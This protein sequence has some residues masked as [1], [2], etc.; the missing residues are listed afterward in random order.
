MATKKPIP[1]EKK[2]AEAPPE[3]TVIENKEL[4]ETPVLKQVPEATEPNKEMP[5]DYNEANSVT[6]GGEIR[7]IKPTKLKYQRTNTTMLY[8]LLR[9]YPLTDLLSMDKDNV[10]DPERDGDQ[11]LFDFLVAVFDDAD[12]VK[13]HYDN[14]DTE[15]IERI[16]DIFCRINKITDKEE[17]VKNRAAKG[18]N[19]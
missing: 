9:T 16:V 3:P 5:K 10:F 8:K 11:M 13:R 14:M 19:N 1:A 12:F 6:I 4:I 7:E 17:Q 2:I 18:T 15:D